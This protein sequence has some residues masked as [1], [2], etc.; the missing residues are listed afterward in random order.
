VAHLDVISGPDRG[1]R[2]ELPPGEPQMLGRSTEALPCSD[3]TVSRRHAELT[4]ARDGWIIRDLASRHGTWLNGVRVRDAV[5]LRDGDRIRCGD[6]E[7]IYRVGAAATAE[8]GSSAVVVGAG[9][10][11]AATTAS[12][13]AAA[14]PIGDRDGHALA[15]RMAAVSHA[16]KNILQGLRGGA[17]AVEM[18]IARGDLAMARQGWPILA[19]NLDR[20]AALTLNMLAW[21][22]ERP[23]D[24]E[25]I[26]LNALV[27]E[28]VSSVASE[29][30]RIGATSEVVLDESLPPAHV[31]PTA[32]HQ[33]LIN[34]ILN[35]IEA[36]PAK[37]G[38][39]RISSSI[40][41]EGDHAVIGVEDNG[42]GIPEEIRD[43]LFQPF[44]SSKGQRGTGLGLAVTRMLVA[45]HGGT[46]SHED[47]SG[48][49]AR[50]KI[51]LPL[52]APAD[53]PGDTKA[54]R[55]VPDA[56]IDF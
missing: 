50:M 19:R 49:G 35:A 30:R 56:G 2:L 17:D 1:S 28:V 26:D 9:S 37:G 15:E 22:R 5:H 43:R 6:S 10:P 18:S 55:S 44:V 47:R 13:L 25:P 31:D 38:R 34:L 46:I 45:A 11:A 27:R 24:R 36:V 33:A 42:P 48:G 8:A 40:S 14:H 54:P 41:I 39:I 3:P 21:S 53:D 51:S 4:P 16:I 12:S 20:I 29:S 32:I 52:H 23:L 7:L